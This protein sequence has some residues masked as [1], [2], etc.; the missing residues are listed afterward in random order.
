MFRDARTRI[1]DNKCEKNNLL[2]RIAMITAS[3]SSDPYCMNSRGVPI[4]I[5]SRTAKHV[6]NSR[7]EIYWGSVSCLFM[8][9]NEVRQSMYF[10]WEN[11]CR[12]FFQKKCTNSSLYVKYSWWRNG[13][14]T[15]IREEV[16]RSFTHHMA[17][18]DGRGWGRLYPLETK[19]E[20]IEE[21]MLKSVFQAYIQ[22]ITYSSLA[23]V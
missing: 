20:I 1:N 19:F 6:S 3:K 23:N 9:T 12:S 15:G 14:F 21:S 7:R 8:F 2:L 13:N 18:V 5:F 16:G 10:E 22:W 4:H 11:S 17:V